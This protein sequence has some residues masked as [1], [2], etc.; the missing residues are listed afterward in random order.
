MTTY[1]YADCLERSFRV[2][3]KI[4]D[5][6]GTLAFDV[7]R[8]WLPAGLSGAGGIFC[9]DA[10]EKKKLT[11]VEMGAYA[12]LFGFVEAFIA[13]EMLDLARDAEFSDE[14]AFSALTNFAAEEVKHMHLFRILRKQV[15]GLLGF[16]LS[17]LEGAQEAAR[18][19]LGRNRGAVLLLTSAI[20]W[21]TQQHYLSAMKDSDE[22]DPLTKEVFRN[23][24]LEESQHARLD[25]LET[26]R[27]FK[28]MDEAERDTAIEDLVWLLAALDGLLQQQVGHDLANLETYLGRSFTEAEQQ[29][30][31]QA[32]LKAKRHAFIESGVTHPNFLELFLSVTTP[33]QQRRVQGA[34]DLLF[35]ETRV[36]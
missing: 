18:A 7:N 2:N 10:E 1:S 34:L 4:K 15:D 17:L 36:S 20:E 12:H 22:L 8:P 31:R 24:W 14:V 28:E 23:H 26:L 9:L 16:P 30:I 11:H 19:I 33:A 27:V 21:F 29:E 13:P 3:W 35:Q 25:H 6:L 32:L 5:V